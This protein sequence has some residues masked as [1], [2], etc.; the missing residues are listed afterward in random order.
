MFRSIPAQRSGTAST[1]LRFN[2]NSL[3]GPFYR[4][5]VSGKKVFYLRFFF[6]MPCWTWYAI[7]VS[8]D[9]RAQPRVKL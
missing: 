5:N 1:A 8:K 3:L 2:P 7:K 4:S 9:L 6:R